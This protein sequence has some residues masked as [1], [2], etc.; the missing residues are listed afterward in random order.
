M[1]FSPFTRRNARLLFED[2]DKVAYIQHPDL[3]GDLCDA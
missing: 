3:L 1:R 2:A